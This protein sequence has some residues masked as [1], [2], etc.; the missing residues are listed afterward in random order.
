MRC[1]GRGEEYL[2]PKTRCEVVLMPCDRGC[3]TLACDQ[4]PYISTVPKRQARG[5]RTCKLVRKVK[6]L[7]PTLRYN[8]ISVQKQMHM[9][10][11]MYMWM[12]CF[13]C[14]RTHS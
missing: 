7:S 4:A 13:I 6:R 1:D 11:C 2:H 12:C 10:M 5:T 9:H 8:A 3:K 14:P